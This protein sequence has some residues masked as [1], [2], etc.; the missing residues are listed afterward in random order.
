MASS[1]QA[2]EQTFMSSM[3]SLVATYDFDGFDFDIESGLNGARS[4]VNP[5]EGCSNDTYDSKCDIY[6]LSTI[7]NGFHT[8]Y[9]DTMLTLAPQIA[10]IAATQQFDSVWGNYASLVMQTYG[11]LEWVAFQNYNAGCAYGIDLICYPTGSNTLTSTADP[12]VAFSTDLLENWPATTSSGQ[13]TGF[14]NYTSF[15]NPSQVVIGYVVNNS[16]GNSDGSPSVNPYLSVAKDAIQCL[17]THEQ[18]ATY[19]P[20]RTYPGIG[21][22][23]AWSINYD[24]SNNYQFAKSLYP[25]V[26]QGNCS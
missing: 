10:N 14:Q 9:P 5:G 3:N 4:F 15:L 21:G 16:S 26:V 20:P 19:T 17:R 13:I 7:I 11:S 18:C 23:F 25:C 1:P 8:Q 2:F 12:A 22:V 6:Y 24:A